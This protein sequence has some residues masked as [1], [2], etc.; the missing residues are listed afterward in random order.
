MSTY[1]SNITCTSI[2]G[3][4]VSGFQDAQDLQ[5]VL[6]TGNNANLQDINQV[7]TLRAVDVEA[8]A[9][10]DTVK[11][12]AEILNVEDASDNTV[13]EAS[14]NQANSE[15]DLYIY[16]LPSVKPTGGGAS[17]PFKCWNNSTFL[18]QGGTI[19]T[20]DPNIEGRIYVDA[21][22]FLKVSAAAAPAPA[23]A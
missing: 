10:V 19:P 17:V 2:N 9:K 8:L 20:T 18:V 11:M 22:N 5:S 12:A 21:N 7:Q 14:Y 6:Q 4:P 23:E 13:L 15:S 1:G 3:I 16:S